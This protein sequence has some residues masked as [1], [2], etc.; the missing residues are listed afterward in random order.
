M[1]NMIAG[2]IGVIIFAAFAIGL[3][4]SINALPFTIIVG[5]VV[6][7]LVIDYI[8]SLRADRDNGDH[9]R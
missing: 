3:A 2:A 7:M 8:Q 6:L 4:H 5:L 9:R 1:D